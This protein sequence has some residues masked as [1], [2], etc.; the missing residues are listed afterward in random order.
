MSLSG[1]LG[2]TTHRRSGGGICGGG[3]ELGG[4]DGI[5]GEGAVLLDDSGGDCDGG[6]GV[7]PETSVQRLTMRLTM[8]LTMRDA[9]PKQLYCR[10]L[11]RRLCKSSN[12]YTGEVIIITKR[13]H[14]QQ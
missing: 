5:G 12:V 1:W 6:L 2:L 13:W 7:V 11:S 14:L 9:Q 8:V 10:A 3:G 4:G